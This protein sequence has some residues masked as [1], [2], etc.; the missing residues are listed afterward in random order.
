MS[1]HLRRNIII[2]AATAALA[3][4]GSAASPVAAKTAPAV[5]ATANGV[6]GIPQTIEVRAP[7]FANQTVNVSIALAG[8]N[9][10]SLPLAVNGAGS[11]SAVWT[12]SSAGTWTLT[13]AGTFAAATPTTITVAPMSTSTTLFASTALVD[14]ANTIVATVQSNAGNVI[15]SGSVVFTNQFGTR[16]GSAQ[17]S[18]S[19]PSSATATFQ[20]TPP[21]PDTYPITATYVPA[22][23][24]GG[25]ANTAGSQAT[26]MVPALAQIPLVT[27]R[28]PGRFVVGQTTQLTVSVS[29]FNLRGNAA[30]TNNVGGVVTGIS[31]SVPIVNGVATVNWTPTTA[32]NQLISVNFTSTSSQD[33]G[34]F[35]QAIN[36]LGPPPADPMAIVPVGQS[37][38][39][40]ATP[41]T[42]APNT[43]VTLTTASG[44]GSPV[45]ISESGPC[46][47]NG[48]TV[49]SAQRAA[50]CTITVSSPGGVGFAPNTATFTVNT[51]G[52]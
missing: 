22:L 4:A 21:S 38:W 26:N 48:T 37:P 24:A 49:I 2:V 14:V 33:T 35:T 36:V 30:F 5:I 23:G 39:F 7:Q 47:V 51:T 9:T 34:I 52:K 44:S 27:M 17:L 8:T 42:L 29:N 45:S 11:G 25:V 1:L 20:W 15:P 6:V 50:S 10:G 13:G 46:L 16:Y 32:G 31:G 28:L 43:S 19:G 3:L 12:P 18:P 40:V 41:V